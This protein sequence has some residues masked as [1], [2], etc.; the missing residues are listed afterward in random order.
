MR[1][2]RFFSFRVTLLALS[3]L[4]G[5]IAATGTLAHA[6]EPPATTAETSTQRALSLDDVLR[7]AMENNANLKA[8]ALAADALEAEKDA[9]AGH[10][11]PVLRAEANAFLWNSDNI[12]D[13]DTSGFN[14]LFQQMGA[15]VGTAVP[16]ISV[17]VRD[18]FMANVSLMAIQPLMQLFQITHGHRAKTAMFEAAQH[19]ATAAR[20]ALQHQIVQA[21]YGNLGAAEMLGTVAKAEQQI[22][23]F[24]TLTRNYVAAGLIEKDALLKI[25]V[26]KEELAKSRLMAEK[27]VKLTR[28]QLNM[29]MRRPIAAPLAVTC[30]ACS[31]EAQRN[32][33]TTPNTTTNPAPSDLATL[34]DAA[35]KN[36][37]ELLAARAKRR[38]ADAG[39]SAAIGKLLPEINLVARYNHNEGMG[40]FALKDEGFGAIMLAWNFWDWGANWNEMKAADI[41]KAEADARIAAAEDGMRLLVEQRTLELEEAQKQR[42]V[43]T[44]AVALAEENLRLEENRYNVQQTEAADLIS[45]QTSLVRARNDRTLAVMQVELARRA[46]ALATGRDLL[47]TTASDVASADVARN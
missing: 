5:G 19:D 14:A 37:P 43:A 35:V 26:Q 10:F 3:T 36:R 46:L 4:V 39:H 44:A 1:T 22:A 8:E 33:A 16:P 6:A 32:A 2:L 15:P 47:D 25:Q 18:Q 34:Q 45:A 7:E 29:L 21:F 42:D 20:H 23:A 17:T 30:D 28:A 11:G 40:D 9:M 38:A 31:A 27:G 13:F 12:Y 41:R 24:E